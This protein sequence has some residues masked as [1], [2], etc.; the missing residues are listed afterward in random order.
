MNQYIDREAVAQL[1]LDLYQLLLVCGDHNVRGV[2]YATRLLGLP[3]DRVE[4]ATERALAM[5]MI[6]RRQDGKYALKGA[7]VALLNAQD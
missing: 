1:D 4:L 3:Q 5:R 6:K 7:G 2:G